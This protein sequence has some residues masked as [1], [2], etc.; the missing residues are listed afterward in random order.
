M[1]FLGVPYDWEGSSLR[2]QLLSQ[3]ISSTIFIIYW[4]T[5]TE[6]IAILFILNYYIIYSFLIHL[7]PLFLMQKRI[8][9]I[10]VNAPFLA[11]TDPLFFSCNILKLNDIFTYS[12]CI[13]MFKN[14]NL[15][16][17]ISTHGF[18]S[19][20]RWKWI[21]STV[22]LF[23][24]WKIWHKTAMHRFLSRKS[25]RKSNQSSSSLNKLN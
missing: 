21:S 10:L 5:P 7:Q 2:S 22:N 20:F 25:L 18:S 24:N 17:K 9:R 15:F 1:R 6:I 11:H 19:K 8:I 23:L 4:C 13:F 3:K 16:Q 12:L 14:L